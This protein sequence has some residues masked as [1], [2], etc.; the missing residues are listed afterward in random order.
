MIEKPRYIL[1]PLTGIIKDKSLWLEGQVLHQRSHHTPVEADENQWKNIVRVISAYLPG[2][3]KSGMLEINISGE[4]RT[5]ALTHDGFFNIKIDNLSPD[6][7]IPEL[8]YHFIRKN[9]R[10][11]VHIPEHYFRE[12]FHYNGFSTGVI[13]DIDD[14]ILVSHA[15][16]YLQ[17]IKQLLIKNAYRRKAVHQMSDIYQMLQQKNIRPFYVS[18]SEANLY[19]MIH[20]FLRHH[21]FPDGPVFLKPYKKWK[22]FL[23]Q[24]HHD[25]YSKHKKEK[26]LG[27]LSLFQDKNFIL[28][29]DDSQKD[30][31]IYTDIAQ[32]HPGRIKAIFIRKTRK[33]IKPKTVK[34]LDKFSRE[35][36]TSFDFFDEPAYLRALI[37]ETVN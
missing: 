36:G 11:K 20:L 33:F 26:I 12:I 6:N 5:L 25:F 30:P 19:P 7:T 34:I 17:K 37:Q 27:I 14:T 35:T 10:H 2:N 18:N 22:D 32:H 21:G 29:G 13:S 3:M 28:I 9:Q 31:E 15:R 23:K 16:N 4:H 8:H 1:L 24:R